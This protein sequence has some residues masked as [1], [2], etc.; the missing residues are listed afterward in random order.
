[1]SARTLSGLGAARERAGTIGATLAQS[2]RFVADAA[3][4]DVVMIDGRG[5]WPTRIAEALTIGPQ[6]LVLLDPQPVEPSALAV[7]SAALDKTQTSLWI[8]E[9]SAGHPALAPWRE[10]LAPE[11]AAIAM[12]SVGDGVGMGVGE[13]SRAAL[14]LRQ[15][16]LARAAGFP[17][18]AIADAQ[19]ADRATIVTA[20]ACH[21]TGE[22]VL[23]AVVSV[24]NG[25]EAR[26]GLDIYSSAGIASLSVSDSGEALPATASIMNA[27]GER[28]MPA[29]YEH[30]HRATLRAIAGGSGVPAGIDDLAADIA[31]ALE[32]AR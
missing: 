10:A 19:H 25:R 3:E 5:D 30:A 13:G 21:D 9:A 27:E 29:I 8:S 16:R 23:R 18:I 14:I 15:L 26:H 32:A 2:F 7:G 6:H 4:A 12:H 28:V 31:L 20:R 24:R 17:V 22:V 11:V 1:M